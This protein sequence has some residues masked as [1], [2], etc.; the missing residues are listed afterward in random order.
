MKVW[1]DGHG[2]ARAKGRSLV[3]T[4]PHDYRRSLAHCARKTRR[5]RGSDSATQLTS[6]ET[7]RRTNATLEDKKSVVEV[8]VSLDSGDL[9]P[10]IYRCPEDPQ[11]CI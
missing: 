10:P 11:R 9:W 6:I 7:G 2:I 8:K 4:N 3:G 5:L 1:P